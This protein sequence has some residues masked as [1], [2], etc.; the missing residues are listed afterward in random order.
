[1][2]LP[3]DAFQSRQRAFEEAFFQKVDAKLLENLRSELE[4]VED[5]NNLA[6]VSGILDEKVLR[7]LVRVGVTAESLLAMRFVPMVYVAWSDRKISA[8]EQQAILKAA[9]SENVLPNS[10]PYHLLRTWLERAPDSAVFAAWKEYV[11]ALAHVMPADS[12]TELRERTKSLCYQVAKAAGGVMGIGSISPAE[13]KAI[14]ECVN[15]W[16]SS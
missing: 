13:Q 10:P 4:A 2:K 14:D 16:K 12:L 1:M 3:P 6:H 11:E 7:E 9:E 8:A 5:A 15:T